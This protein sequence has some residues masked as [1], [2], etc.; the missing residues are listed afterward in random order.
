MSVA[1]AGMGEMFVTDAEATFTIGA[2]ARLDGFLF[3]ALLVPPPVF[4]LFFTQLAA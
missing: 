3:A 1:E 4:G 2:R